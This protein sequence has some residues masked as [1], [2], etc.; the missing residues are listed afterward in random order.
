MFAEETIADQ[1]AN[2]IQTISIATIKYLDLDRIPIRLM[3]CSLSI[4]GNPL[5]PTNNS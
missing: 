5:R 3:L 2:Q 1:D 4:V